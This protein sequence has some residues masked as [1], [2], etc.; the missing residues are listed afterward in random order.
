MQ[1]ESP[2]RLINCARAPAFQMQH[3]IT[4]EL[5]GQ[6]DIHSCPARIASLSPRT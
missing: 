6:M 5:R 4:P 3:I 1:R 2:G